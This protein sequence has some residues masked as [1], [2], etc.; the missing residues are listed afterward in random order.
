[1]AGQENVTDQLEIAPSTKTERNSKAIFN[2]KETH[3]CQASK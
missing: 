3:L 2:T 1:M